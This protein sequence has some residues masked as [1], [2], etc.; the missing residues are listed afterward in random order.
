[1][2][3]NK[4]SEQPVLSEGVGEEFQP[5]PNMTPW[6]LDT[7][8]VLNGE[9]VEGWVGGAAANVA[10]SWLKG[11]GYAQGFYEIS[12]KGRDYLAALSKATAQ[13]KDGA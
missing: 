7:L 11:R 4:T 10:C 1:M 8:R 5:D 2:T 3:M 13:P 12:Q 6:E 9:D